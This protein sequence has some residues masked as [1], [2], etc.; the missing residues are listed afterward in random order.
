MASIMTR[1]VSSAFMDRGMDLRRSTKAKALARAALLAFAGEQPI[2]RASER[3][4]GG[5]A[6]V[7]RVTLAELMEA[8][9]CVPNRANGRRLLMVLARLG[10]VRQSGAVAVE[11]GK[12]GAIRTVNGY[13]TNPPLVL[14]VKSRAVV[15]AANAS[16]AV[17]EA[18]K[19]A[20]VTL[21]EMN[22]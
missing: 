6:R 20:T 21:E 17:R 11:R 13:E 18:A 9:G 8:S 7:L 10:L 3:A 4:E 5:E 2:K 15:C 14:M 19:K 22:R 12:R 1:V 16:E